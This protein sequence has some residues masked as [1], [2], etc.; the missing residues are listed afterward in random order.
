MA[1]SLAEVFD[2]TVHG[3]VGVAGKGPVASEGDI[4]IL[5]QDGLGGFL[6][7]EAALNLVLARIVAKIRLRPALNS[8]LCPIVAKSRPDA[9]VV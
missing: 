6:L 7:L 1:S 8:I 2:A 5:L 3:L 9:C 4:L